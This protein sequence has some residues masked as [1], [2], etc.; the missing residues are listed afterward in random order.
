M[1]YDRRL[2]VALAC[3]LC[4]GVGAAAWMLYLP[5][6]GVA[7]GQD[8]M[9]FHTV[10]RAW[11]HGNAALADEPNRLTAL[12]NWKFRH[13]LAVSLDLHPWLYPPSFLLLLLPFGAL[14]FFPAWAAFQ[15]VTGGLLV[16][17]LWR[18][19]GAGRWRPLLVLVVLASPAA[20]FN[21]IVGQNGFLT[22]ALFVAGFGLL[23]ARPLLGGVALGLLTLKPQLGVLIPLAL[24]A[25]CNPRAI[26]GA[27]LG[28]LGLALASLAVF[29]ARFW[30]GWL[31]M[32]LGGGPLLAEWDRSGR[33]YGTSLFA[34][35]HALGAGFGA[36]N[37][38]QLAGTAGAA[39][40]T[41][42]IWRGGRPRAQKFAGLLAATMLAAP[43]VSN[44]DMMVLAVGAGLLFC[45]ALESGRAEDGMRAGPLALTLLLWACPLANPPAALPIGLLTPPLLLGVLLLLARRSRPLSAERDASRRDAMALPAYRL[46]GRSS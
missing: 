40:L 30:A 33:E 11:L 21:L 32:M 27:A 10:A 14:P 18:W 24:L 20:A 25:D 31:R 5:A 12:I 37:L 2:V 39:A 42:V 3:G 34:N 19:S 9:V 22:A 4:A 41:W 8:W 17:A 23:P 36:A 44:Y 1:A 43:H 16:A 45:A 46:P 7:A 6:L 38:V 13:W 29:G 26:A 35:A 15:C 28:G